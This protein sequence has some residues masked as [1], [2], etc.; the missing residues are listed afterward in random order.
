MRMM[1]VSDAVETQRKWRPPSDT[2]MCYF[3]LACWPL[4]NTIKDNITRLQWLKSFPP[5]LLGV[6]I[7]SNAG[8]YLN[9]FIVRTV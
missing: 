9:S 3:M 4:L 8:F 2:L 7:R 1:K 5:F 6:F